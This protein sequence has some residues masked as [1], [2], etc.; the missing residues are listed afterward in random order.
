MQKSGWRHIIML[1]ITFG[2]FCSVTNYL[3]MMIMMT[4]MTMTTAANEA[5]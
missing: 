5:I 1:I 2:K 4:T 3:M